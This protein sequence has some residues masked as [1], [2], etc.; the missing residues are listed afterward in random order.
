MQVRC[1]G[2]ED[3]AVLLSGEG[4]ETFKRRRLLE[5]V[6]EMHMI[7]LDENKGKGFG[8]G[9]GAEA[10][11]PSVLLLSNPR[12]FCYFLVTGDLSALKF[13]TLQRPVLFTSGEYGVFV[14]STARSLQCW[15]L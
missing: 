3:D 5:R 11:E 14:G 15:R 4:R 10:R 13:T 1:C 8:R 9:T 12:L 2:P 6:L 7:W